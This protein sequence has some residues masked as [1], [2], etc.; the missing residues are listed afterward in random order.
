M[1][2][3]LFMLT[4]GG[5]ATKCHVLASPLPLSS[6][7]PPVQPRWLLTALRIPWENP[8]LRASTATTASYLPLLL[9]L[10]H[11]GVL[12]KSLLECHFIPEAASWYNGHNGHCTM[13]LWEAHCEVIKENTH[14]I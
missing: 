4:V 9:C 10:P 2:P 5:T 12:S 13:A 6:S 11:S 7:C 1:E 14:A 8:G 3:A